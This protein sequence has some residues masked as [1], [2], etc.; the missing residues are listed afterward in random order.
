MD[1]RNEIEIIRSKQGFICDMDGVI[2][3]G[4]KLI[5]G[6]F[7]FV[8]W[9][10]KN[11]KRYLFLTNAS[12][13]TPLGLKR[14]LARLGLDIDESKFYTSALATAQFLHSQSPGCSAYVIGDSGLHHALNEKGISMDEVNP[15]YVVVGETRDYNY[16]KISRA[17]S[18]VAN[19][20]RLIGTHPDMAGPGEEGLLPAARALVAPIEMVTGRKAYFVGKPNALMMR[21][22][23]S[24]LGVHSS[25]A[26]IIGDR[27]DTDIIA[28][29]ETGIM[30]ILVLTGVT[31]KEQIESFPYRPKYVFE[32][33]SE[34]A[35]QLMQEKTSGEIPLA[36]KVRVPQGLLRNQVER[37][38]A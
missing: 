10:E 3:Y 18:F 37:N 9:L 12:A 32:G 19:G 15:D 11:E 13:H 27:M 22:G 26:A 29:I 21:T 38:I 16:D 23:I 33:I 31:S 6:A 24:M 8:Q 2:Y 30:T 36:A 4:E 20:A 14:R 34:L 17:I 7:E 28:G 35:V 25:E 5:K 1:L